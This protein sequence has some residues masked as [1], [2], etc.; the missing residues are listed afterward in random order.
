MDTNIFM[1]ARA[2]FANNP[3]FP[4][5]VR[6][7]HSGTDEHGEKILI[8]SPKVPDI[9]K[10]TSAQILEYTKSFRT[11]TSQVDVKRSR[12]VSAVRQDTTDI[13]NQERAYHNRIKAIAKPLRDMIDMYVLTGN[14]Q[15]LI[16]TRNFLSS[17]MKLSDRALVDLDQHILDLAD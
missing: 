2:F 9:D 7:V 4:Q 16:N 10:V 17:T 11:L 6:Q 1:N 13:L 8:A 3:D 12:D 14:R 5:V 15:E